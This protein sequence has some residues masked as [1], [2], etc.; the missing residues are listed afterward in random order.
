MADMGGAAPEITKKR[1][2]VHPTTGREVK[3][4]HDQTMADATVDRSAV[5]DKTRRRSSVLYTRKRRGED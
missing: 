4:K 5:V 1:K 3:V 2:W